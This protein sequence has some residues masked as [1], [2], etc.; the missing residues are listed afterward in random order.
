MTRASSNEVISAL[1]KANEQTSREL[2]DLKNRLSSIES[3]A[4][5]GVANAVKAGTA[6]ANA[7]ERAPEDGSDDAA[8]DKAV[9]E[10]T[11]LGQPTKT[12]SALKS[13][14]AE[15]SAS[16]P[17]KSV[18]FKHL[19]SLP[20]RST[21]DRPSTPDND[22]D[23]SSSAS[24]EDTVAFQ[25][26]ARVFFQARHH[27]TSTQITCPFSPS[28]DTYLY[29]RMT[30]TASAVVVSSSPSIHA[31]PLIEIPMKYFY[32]LKIPSSHTGAALFLKNDSRKLRKY[33]FRFEFRNTVVHQPPA[34]FLQFVR[35]GNAAKKSMR[36]IDKV[37][38]AFQK[39]GKEER[40][41]VSREN[42]KR[43][44]DAFAAHLGTLD[45][46]L[47]ES[48]ELAE[49][50]VKVFNDKNEEMEEEEYRIAHLKSGG[51]T[52]AP[53]RRK[54]KPLPPYW[55][56]GFNRQHLEEED[57]DE[58]SDGSEDDEEDYYDEEDDDDET[59]FDKVQVSTE[60]TLETLFRHIVK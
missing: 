35:S 9:L 59:F 48:N 37:K 50:F 10:G 47:Q 16:L 45:E 60:Q 55:G 21:N 26:H 42:T 31:A 30:S 20:E 40:S 43:S 52:N 4:D 17:I 1:L 22:D 49:Q 5:G 24:S 39:L 19:Q 29:V 14:N 23:S 6:R 33:I 54:T 13:T 32:A 51:V 56:S 57:D 2:N 27:R 11:P 7:D 8:S 46:L 41:E 44:L 53:S 58:E 15:S 18:K 3:K 12:P 25:G 36:S 28:Q 38:K 34:R